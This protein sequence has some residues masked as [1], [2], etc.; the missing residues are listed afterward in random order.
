MF[1]TFKAVLAHD[2]DAFARTSTLSFV[3]TDLTAYTVCRD[4]VEGGDGAIALWSASGALTEE[5]AFFAVLAL[6]VGVRNTRATE[7]CTAPLK[8][9]SITLL[10]LC[11][12]PGDA[13]GGGV[14]IGVAC[15]Q[16]V[17]FAGFTE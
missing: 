1:A 13:R 3:V 4:T 12:C 10:T 11:V 9:A 8:S 2:T 16:S 6:C 7:S 5:C 15:A 17:F 14:W